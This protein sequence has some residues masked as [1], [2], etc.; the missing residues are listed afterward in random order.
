MLAA[1]LSSVTFCQD[2]A[3]SE[4]FQYY[5]FLAKQQIEIGLNLNKLGNY[6]FECNEKAGKCDSFKIDRASFDTLT[7]LFNEAT[8]KVN[9]A[10]FDIIDLQEVDSSIGLKEPVLFLFRG[11]AKMLS[12]YFPVFLSLLQ[13]NKIAYMPD[14]TLTV[15]NI[16]KRFIT[17][18]KDLNS[19]TEVIETA[20]TEF[21]NKYNFT[22]YDILKNGL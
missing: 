13:G 18:M 22:E 16:H 9:K 1:V 11:Y 3:H 4:A 19:Q 10:V 14:P 21:M 20:S 6:L 15:K 2:T 17:L 12:E 7:G 8:T 5:K